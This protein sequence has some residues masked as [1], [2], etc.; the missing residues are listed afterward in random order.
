MFRCGMLGESEVGA[1]LRRND[2]LG[3]SHRDAVLIHRELA[4]GTGDGKVAVG[5]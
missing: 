3:R 4:S 1:F 5:G 2:I